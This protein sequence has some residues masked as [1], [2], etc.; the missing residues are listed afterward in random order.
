MSDSPRV[1]NKETQSYAAFHG[2]LDQLR[3]AADGWLAPEKGVE[4]EI[5]VVDGLRNVI[6]MLS[7]A[8][9][10]Y[11][12]GD[13]ERPE[14]RAIV[15]PIRKFMGDNPDAVYYWARL[16]DDRSY[17]VRG[18]RADECYI[19][20]TVHGRS[21]DGS[22]GP[23]S[24][25]VLA[26]VN[27]RSFKVE[28]DGS[29]EVILSAEKPAN[30]AEVNWI[31]LPKGSASL[32]TRH[33]FEI[34]EDE[35]AAVSRVDKVHLKIET[36]E[37]VPPR[38]P[39]SDADFA[40]RLRDV[41]SFVSGGE[42]VAMETPPP[43]VSTTPNELGTPMVFS[44]AGTDAWGAVDIAYSMGPFALG[45]DEALVIEGSFPECAFANVVLWNR[46]LQSFE[47]RDRRIS[48]NRKQI[49]MGE[50]G[51]YRIVLAAT[52]PQLKGGS[53]N[54]L[55]TENHPTGTIFWRFLLPE[56]APEKPT[57]RVVPVAELAG[58]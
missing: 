25:P 42:Q 16:R 1:T 22:L 33:Y 20:F 13:P 14:F 39:L 21:Q 27:D 48:L 32:L 15:S 40:R 6:H 45:A 23:T 51:R 9:D 8:I 58:T 57:C 19:S 34:D 12:E 38:P 31:E 52:D 10:F 17:R 35:P 24:E 54:W 46:F 49:R 11:L 55:D 41:A 26:D 56:E 18:K 29:Y 44:M 5:D 43:F 47:F 3:E 4:S 7:G 2:L 50:D 53:Q 28:A 30:A 37:Q 36:L